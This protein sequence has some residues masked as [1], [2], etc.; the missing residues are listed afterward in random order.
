MVN[1]VD[2]SGATTPSAGRRARIALV[3][4]WIVVTGCWVLFAWQI[5]DWVNV[6]EDACNIIPSGGHDGVPGW[7]WLPPGPTCTY[8]VKSPQADNLITLTVGDSTF[9][10][11]TAILLLISV[12]LLFA[13]NRRR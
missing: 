12:A 3:T 13:V 4:T 5:F 11:L 2:M 6:A 10:W 9:V 8:Q 7:T 1:P